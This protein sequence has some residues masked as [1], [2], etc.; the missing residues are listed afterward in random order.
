MVDI[1]S[2]DR[3]SYG[4]LFIG[5]KLILVQRETG[6]TEAMIHFKKKLWQQILFCPYTYVLKLRILKFSDLSF[7]QS[8]QAWFPVRLEKS[9]H[10]GSVFQVPEF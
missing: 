7:L 6:S 3:I 5:S 8:K 1:L 2:R 9:K 4:R 10:G